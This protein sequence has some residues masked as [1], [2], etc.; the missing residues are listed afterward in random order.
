MMKWP[1]IL[2]GERRN[3][4]LGPATQRD[5]SLVDWYDG[6][7]QRFGQTVNAMRVEWLAAA[8]AAIDAISGTVASLP[9]MVYRVTEAGRE[10]DT[11]HP[12]ARL[13]R[14][15]PNSHQTWP[16]FMQWLTAQTL[17]HGDQNSVSRRMSKSVV[18]ALEA[19]E[20]DTEYGEF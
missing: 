2:G 15:G 6:G 20:I 11:S 14:D 12:L 1:R 4:T 19:V 18:D 13:V 3:Q 7:D 8:T 5:L 16:D 17:R 10:E 9:A